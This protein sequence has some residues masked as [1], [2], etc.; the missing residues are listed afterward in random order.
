MHPRR[1]GENTKSR[2]L[3]VG[4]FVLVCLFFLFNIFNFNQ[5]AMLY[6]YDDYGPPLAVNRT[7]SKQASELLKQIEVMRNE[8]STFRQKI[9]EQMNELV[10]KIDDLK[11]VA[12]TNSDRLY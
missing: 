9:D 4:T 1:I 7:E 5:S 10:K 8:H 11:L 2:Q 6:G 12:T 3:W